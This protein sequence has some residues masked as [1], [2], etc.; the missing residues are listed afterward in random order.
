MDVNS[1][2]LNGYIMEKVCV[3][4]P[5]VFENFDFSHHVYKLKKTLY[6]LKQAPR[7]W[8]DRLSNFL[9]ENDFKMSK[10]DTTLFIKIKEK[11]MLLVQI[12]VDDIIFGSTNPSLCEEFSKC[13]HN[14]FEMSMMGEL[15]FFLGLQIKQLKDGIFQNQEKYIKDLLKKVQVQ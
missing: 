8:Y 7:A 4:Q 9:I 11:Y 12:Y 13:M 5:P 10:L 3:K 2:F 6:G 1:T 15:N 14:E